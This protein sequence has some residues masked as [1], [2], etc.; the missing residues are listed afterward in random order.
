MTASRHLL[1]PSGPVLATVSTSAAQSNYSQCQEAINSSVLT[2]KITH[3]Y[4]LPHPEML[5]P[6]EQ[7]SPYVLIKPMWDPGSL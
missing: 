1:Q 7:L 3:R 4:V 6:G 2:S 5:L